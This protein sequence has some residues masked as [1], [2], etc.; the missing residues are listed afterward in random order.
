M[1]AHV[2]AIDPGRSMGVALMSPEGNP[3]FHCQLEMRDA[4]SRWK[5]IDR[6]VGRCLKRNTD[7]VVVREKWQSGGPKFRWSTAQIAGLGA[8]WGIWTEQFRLFAPWIP[9]SRFHAVYPSTWR[10]KVLRAHA[11]SREGWAEL[12]RK[13]VA[14]RFGVDAAPDEAVALCIGAYA[15]ASPKIIASAQEKPRWH[16]KVPQ[17]WSFGSSGAKIVFSRRLDA[18][19]PGD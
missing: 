3:V 12:A 16:K 6:A 15:F 11:K 8:A 2:L 5:L 13:Y 17:E 14:A 1:N 4:V 19:H 18:G 10:S 7:L 9:Q